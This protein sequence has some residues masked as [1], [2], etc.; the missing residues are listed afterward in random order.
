MNRWHFF[1]FI[2][3]VGDVQPGTVQTF[4]RLLQLLFKGG[5]GTGVIFRYHPVGISRLAIFLLG[6]PCFRLSLG[7]CLGFRFGRLLLLIQ[8]A[9]GLLSELRHSPVHF[10]RINLRPPFKA[11]STQDLHRYG[12]IPF[13]ETR[14]R[15]VRVWAFGTL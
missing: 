11:T 9:L 2:T 10:L 6:L 13:H 15:L 14:Q 3:P 12:I 1:F 8:L 4:D 5:E 7:F